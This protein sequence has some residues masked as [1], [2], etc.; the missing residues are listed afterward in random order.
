MGNVEV[1]TV[2]Q[3]AVKLQCTI[4]YVYNLLHAER[5]SGAYREDGEWR[6]PLAAV[7]AYQETR[8]R[9]VKLIRLEQTQSDRS[10]A[11]VAA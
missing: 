11:E 9:R 3:A 8:S 7:E 5:L 2:R 10:V 6:L 1:L 4:P